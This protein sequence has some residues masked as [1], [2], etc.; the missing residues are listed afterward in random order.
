LRDYREQPGSFDRVVSVGMFEHVGKRN[1]REFFETLRDRLADDGVALLHSIGFSDIPAPINPFIRKYIFPGADLPSLSEVFA[2]VE[3]T[4]LFVTDIEI[5]HLHYADT[6]REW[7]RRFM[8]KRDEAA[9][10]YDERFCRMW[11]FYLV[12]GELGFRRRAMMV[13]QIQLAKRM[14]AVPLTRNYIGD[15][16]QTHMPDQ[17]V[18]SVAS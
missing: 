13:F 5:L 14:D 8:A 9:A 4:G 15:W 1:Y 18:H 10:I 6:L 16:E 2:A 12:L 7:R 3:P 11:E 17:R